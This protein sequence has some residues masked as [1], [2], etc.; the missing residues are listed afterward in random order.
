MVLFLQVLHPVATK[1]I[2]IPVDTEMEIAFPI[3]F[4]T[5]WLGKHAKIVG[6]RK[7]KKIKRSPATIHLR[8]LLRPHFSKRRLTGFHCFIVRKSLRGKGDTSAS[9]IT[10]AS[11]SDN[12]ANCDPVDDRHGNPVSH[13]FH[14][15]LAR[16]T[17]E[18]LGGGKRKRLTPS[19]S[20]NK[21]NCDAVDDRDGN[22]VSHSF[23]YPLARKT[24]R[25]SGENKASVNNRQRRR[26]PIKPRIHR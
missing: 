17:R 18:I 10:S 2:A 3:D 24:R 15:P 8:E 16:K 20:G 26:N 4:I 1:P 11:Q 13:R 12:K 6:Q 19:P 5:L 25:D 22:P 14:Y 23:H 21:A 7:D 9:I